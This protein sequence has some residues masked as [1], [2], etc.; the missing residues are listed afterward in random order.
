MGVAVKAYNSN[1]FTYEPVIGKNGAQVVIPISS[2]QRRF[3]V[4]G[5]ILG[6][7][8]SEQQEAGMREFVR[9]TPSGL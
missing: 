8:P 1:T 4:E 7:A 9:N 5:V 2:I 6:A 3:D